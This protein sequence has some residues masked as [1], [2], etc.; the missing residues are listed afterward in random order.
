MKY[1]THKL[2]GV[3]SSFAVGNVI[4]SDIS[5]F[6]RVIF[7]IVISTVGGFGGTF[8]DVDAKNNNWNKMFGSIFKFRHRGKM[9]S[10]IPYIIVYFIIYK[11]IL[12]SVQRHEL[13]SLYI[14]AI[15]GFL[16]GVIS[17]LALDI[18]TVRGVPILYPFT[19]KNYRILNLRTEKHDKYISFILKVLI[20]IYIFKN[21]RIYI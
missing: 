6:K 11:K 21:I 18:I 3:I 1:E 14:I 12:T 13:V 19:K 17:H 4:L 2:C 20:A 7:L 8:P 10:L 5:I 15:S 16:I 9:H